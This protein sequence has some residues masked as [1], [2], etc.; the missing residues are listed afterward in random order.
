MRRVQ[1]IIFDLDG[2]LVDSKKDIANSVNFTLRSLGL[3][4]KDDSLIS[5][6]V[7]RGIEDLIKKSLGEKNS[8]YFSK[9]LDIFIDYIKKHAVDNT[10]LYPGVRDI[11]E[12]FKDKKKVIITNRKYEIADIVLK[13]VGISGYFN[14]V[15]G[16][17]DLD[18]MK[19][20]SC[21]LDKVIQRFNIA[22]TAAAIVGDMDIDVLTGKSAGVLTCAVTYGIGKR[23]DI[24]K[25]KPDY[26]IDNIIDLK[27]II[28]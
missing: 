23:A 17:D 10:V 3:E 12:Y 11:L 6:Y 4:E 25:A 24:I 28:S 27:N 5:S 18:C 13:G 8:A 2:T 15:I 21:P 1:L 20:N 9:A 19:P 22:K 7:G 14:E 16:G 26:I